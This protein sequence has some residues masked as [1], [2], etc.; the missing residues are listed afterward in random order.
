MP[1]DLVYCIPP[2]FLPHYICTSTKVAAVYIVFIYCSINV[3]SSVIRSH[4]IQ[5]QNSFALCN[6]KRLNLFFSCHVR[7]YSLFVLIST[8]ILTS[9]TSVME[10]VWPWIPSNSSRSTR[11][12]A[13]HTSLYCPKASP[14]VSHIYKT[15]LKWSVPMLARF[16]KPVYCTLPE[17]T[18]QHPSQYP[19]PQTQKLPIIFQ[20]TILWSISCIKL[21]NISEARFWA[22]FLL[23]ATFELQSTLHY[24]CISATAFNPFS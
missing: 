10:L 18:K 19:F 13:L 22:D 14:Q 4:H 1:F 15:V 20:H 16:Q 2:P 8:V 5:P 24:I 3:I 9:S 12:P 21:F 11:Y 17:M 6:R 23:L 7:I